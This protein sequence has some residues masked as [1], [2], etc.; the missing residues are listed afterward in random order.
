MT[1]RTPASFAAQSSATVPS[2]FA[3]LLAIGSATERGTLGSA[4]SWKMTS[5]PPTARRSAAGS[6]KS[7]LITFEPALERGQ[8]LLAAGGKIVQDAHARAALEERSGD[9]RPDE[10]RPAGN[11][12]VA[13]EGPFHL[14]LQKT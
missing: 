8:V 14:A 9:V 6:F 5:A 3:R 11:Q 4:A 13:H 10:P 7:P 2:M 1:R 12:P